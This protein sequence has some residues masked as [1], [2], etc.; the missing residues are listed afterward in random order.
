MNE[1][2]KLLLDEYLKD[3]QYKEYNNVLKKEITYF[4]VKRIQK[5]NKHY[6]YSTLVELSEDVE[7]IL[8]DRENVIFKKF[9]KIIK[10]HYDDKELSKRLM[11]IYERLV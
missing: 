1:R 5:T 8:D 9:Y 7:R 10:Q 6:L 2:I 11:E 3:N 4:F